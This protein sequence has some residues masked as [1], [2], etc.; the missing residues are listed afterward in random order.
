MTLAQF[1]LSPDATKIIC[2]AIFLFFLWQ[3]LRFTVLI[4]T[5]NKELKEF[6]EFLQKETSADN[7]DSF[8]SERKGKNFSA[9]WEQYK[10]VWVK[11]DSTELPVF[12]NEFYST[13]SSARF[14][15]ENNCLE[16]KLNMDWF[17]TVPSILTGLGILFTFL[18]LVLGLSQEGPNNTAVAT[19]FYK[20]IF[21]GAAIAFWSSVFGLI[22]SVIFTTITKSK[23][24]KTRSHLDSITNR[25]DTLIPIMT[26]QKIS[27]F[28]LATVRRSSD[29]EEGIKEQFSNFSQAVSISLKDLLTDLTKE[30]SASLDKKIQA[31]ADMFKNSAGEI[32][33]SLTALSDT[34]DSFNKQLKDAGDAVLL[35]FKE[36]EN[37]TKNAFKNLEETNDKFLVHLQDNLNT[38]EK[39]FKEITVAHAEQYK[40]DEADFLETRKILSSELEQCVAD[41]VGKFSDI[42]KSFI[43]LIQ[44]NLEEVKKRFAEF[45]EFNNKQIENT[46]KVFVQS[47]ENLI[48]ELSDQ[49]KK[50]LLISLLKLIML[51]L[52]QKRP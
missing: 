3:T 16:S 2:G 26:P 24:F 48:L 52:V 22:T 21:H 37:S 30:F 39:N 45:S 35:N 14:F 11:V 8:F 47:R 6:S 27:L 23:I 36:A 31:S 25:L 17:H 9:L 29:Y 44:N 43:T 18:G 4:G 10:G 13:E 34:V 12:R 46:E 51:P 38:V 20:N 42:N 15:N 41:S 49:T 50:L 1:F 5:P 28:T 7:L 33:K 40:K 19:D 32:E